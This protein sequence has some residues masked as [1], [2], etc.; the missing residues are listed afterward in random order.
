VH[1]LPPRQLLI[2]TQGRHTG[3]HPLGWEIATLTWIEVTPHSVYT[4]SV[5]QT[6]PAPHRDT[7]ETRIDTYLAP[8]ARVV[9][10]QPG[11][12]LKYVAVDGYVSKKKCV[13]GIGALHLHVIS[14]LRRDAHR[15]PLDRGPRGDGPGRP[16]PS[17]GTVNISDLS[18][19]EQSDADEADITLYSQAVHHPQ[20][21]RKRRLVVVRHLPP[22]R[23][24]LLFSTDD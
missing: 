2:I 23:Y 3:R 11:Q 20:L 13:D 18:R 14:K 22:R 12:R 7:E 8:I 24:A 19:C 21:K 16:K 4:L 5:E 1:F 15:R 6:A 10:T 9:T 17:D